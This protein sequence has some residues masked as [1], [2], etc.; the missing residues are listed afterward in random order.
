VPRTVSGEASHIEV[1]LEISDNASY[2]GIGMQ[3]MHQ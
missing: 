2:S 3:A 1:L